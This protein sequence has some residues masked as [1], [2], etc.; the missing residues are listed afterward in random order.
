M[1]H[2]EASNSDYYYN[3]YTG[4]SS[5]V[6]PQSMVDSERAA[7]TYASKR[8]AFERGRREAYKKRLSE[9]RRVKQSLK[10]SE[11]QVIVAKNVHEGFYAPSDTR[12]RSSAL[13]LESQK[14]RKQLLDSAVQYGINDNLLFCC[15]SYRS[16]RKNGARSKDIFLSLAGRHVELFNKLLD[17]E[18]LLSLHK[19]KEAER[20]RYRIAGGTRKVTNY[21]KRSVRERFLLVALEAYE[22]AYNMRLPPVEVKGSSKDGIGTDKN[23]DNSVSSVLV[24]NPIDKEN[25]PTILLNIAKVYSRLNLDGQCANIVLTLFTPD[26]QQHATSPTILSMSILSFETLLKSGGHDN[27]TNACKILKWIVENVEDAFSSIIAHNTARERELEAHSANERSKKQFIVRR[28]KERLTNVAPPAFLATTISHLEEDDIRK[29]K[30]IC[31]LTYAQ[32][33][34]KMGNRAEAMVSILDAF[35]LA[36][37]VDG[38]APGTIHDD[39]VKFFNDEVTWAHAGEMAREILCHDGERIAE[40]CYTQAILRGDGRASTIKS[41]AYIQ[42]RTNQES[43]AVFTCVNFVNSHGFWDPDI[44]GLLYCLSPAF[45]QR[46][47]REERASIFLN[48]FARYVLARRRIKNLKQEALLQKEKDQE[49]LKKLVEF[50]K[51]KDEGWIK[52]TFFK[53]EEHW[54]NM[55][56][57]KHEAAVILQCRCKIINARNELKRRKMHAKYVDGAIRDNLLKILGNRKLSTMTKWKDY[58]KTKKE[59]KCS[60]RIQDF[61]RMVLAKKKVRQ[62]KLIAKALGKSTELMVKHCVIAWQRFVL[63]N[64]KVKTAVNMQRFVR[65]RTGRKIA[66][67]AN[68]TRER[69]ERIILMLT[70]KSKGN[71]LRD[72]Y[73]NWKNTV[74]TILHTRNATKIQKIV[75]MFLGKMLLALKKRQESKAKEMALLVMGKNSLRIQKIF[76]DALYRLLED[77]AAMKLQ[78][79][80]RGKNGKEELKRRKE[81]EKKIKALCRRCLGGAGHFAMDGWKAFIVMIR[82]EKYHAANKI[83]NRAKVVLAKA[84]VERERKEQARKEEL[85]AMALGK[86]VERTAKLCL[87][88]WHEFVEMNKSAT[89]F[90]GL[91]RIKQSKKNVEILK[92]KKR[93]VELIIAMALGRSGLRWKRNFIAKLIVNRKLCK[94]QKRIKKCWFAFVAKTIAK[95]FVERREK[96]KKGML[97]L[98]A[99]YRA[100]MLSVGMRRMQHFVLMTAKANQLQRVLSAILKRIRKRRVEL[101]SNV[102]GASLVGLSVTVV[103]SRW[104]GARRINKV[105][106]RYLWEEKLRA[107]RRNAQRYGEIILKCTK[108]RERRNLTICKREW[109]R[110]Q[111]IWRKSYDC[112]N[113]GIRCS[114]ARRELWRRREHE[115]LI[116][117]R[118]ELKL[119]QK[120]GRIL[121][122]CLKVFSELLVRKSLNKVE[123]FQEEFRRAHAPAQSQ[124]ETEEGASQSQSPTSPAETTPRRPKTLAVTARGTAILPPLKQAVMMAPV[125]YLSNGKRGAMEHTIRQHS[126][127]ARIDVHCKDAL[128]A[129]YF[130]NKKSIERTGIMYWGG[131]MTEHDLIELCRSATVVILNK[132]R[133][134]DV[135][136]LTNVLRIC[137]P[138]YDYGKGVKKE[139][140]R[141]ENGEDYMFTERVE[142]EEEDEQ[143]DDDDLNN[144]AECVLRKVVIV[145]SSDVVIDIR[146]LSQIVCD[147]NCKITSVTISSV[148]LKNQGAI[149]FANEVSKAKTRLCSVDK[150]RYR[151][152]QEVVLE[153]NGIS[154]SGSACLLKSFCDNSAFDLKSFALSE[155]TVGDTA[156]MGNIMESFVHSQYNLRKLRFSKCGLST[157]TKLGE[158][159][160][161][162]IV[163]KL[164][165][166]L[167]QKPPVVDDSGVTR[168]ATRNFDFINLSGN[169]NLNDSAIEALLNVNEKSGGEGSKVDIQFLD[170]SECRLTSR[171]A[172]IIANVL[173]KDVESD[174]LSEEEEESAGEGSC[175][176][177]GD[178]KNC[179]EVDGEGKKTDD[180]VT[181]R[182]SAQKK[183]RNDNLKIVEIDLS[184]NDIADDGAD[185]LMDTSNLGEVVLNL[186]R[187]RMISDS[188]VT[189]EAEKIVKG[190]SLTEAPRIF[191]SDIFDRPSSPL[192]AK[193]GAFFNTIDSFG[194]LSPGKKN[195]LPSLFSK[196]NPFDAKKQAKEIAAKRWWDPIEEANWVP[197]YSIYKD[198]Y[199]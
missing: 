34:I 50:W 143:A 185:A 188:V 70:G 146:C 118:L 33:Y 172:G 112:L 128:S 29:M 45:Q 93:K 159:C 75:R 78:A 51:F 86:S 145:G 138:P 154:Q 42:F 148:I 21:S 89:K 126:L 116:N 193:R 36:Y 83:I 132:C 158:Y 152:L 63:D 46:F 125:D 122:T 149:A 22:T 103:S 74:K 175:S 68:L 114:L 32:L 16:A 191:P 87:N 88:C 92:E 124:G 31:L 173:I 41:L 160:A 144:K 177:E 139:A 168:S 1:E 57:V 28:E 13:L 108:E 113:R 56:T 44:R 7:T 17:V 14:T 99:G 97:L 164:F 4:E 120:R 135:D 24:P 161:D 151:K 190:A 73:E 77:K 196:T 109:E 119:K 187:N 84:A 9:Q 106:K 23:D 40:Y 180:S 91:F 10:I 104:C 150:L 115:R 20:E 199:K 47:D 37:R 12:K 3:N 19:T 198:Y 189:Q 162:N 90:Q 66:K 194:M 30:V 181:D 76:I 52:R 25:A 169:E 38:W 165:A 117:V 62:E 95:R 121:D 184:S 167:F 171:G 157:F 102:V 142:V 5:W 71:M 43:D 15:K 105:A 163:E 195:V 59:Y 174:G 54:R 137:F 170:L 79:I 85:I 136:N 176:Q 186:D 156:V 166:G 127:K 35:T 96:R 69:N 133:Q 81:R 53:L 82:N 48:R 182:K 100:G 58:V 26:F 80:I 129:S 140:K 197:E 60:N 72:S 153:N 130:A 49:N 111:I 147:P 101:V 178:V 110:M 141:E 64:K 98:L 179:V 27:I 94:M 134:S 61:G 192:S 8:F 11:R 2:D 55:R 183:R 65:G 67:A 6:K 155:N 123:A 18:Y 39:A 107:I 131:D